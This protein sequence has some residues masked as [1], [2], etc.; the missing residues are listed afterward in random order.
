MPYLF[1]LI[2]LAVGLGLV[3]VGLNAMWKSNQVSDWPTATG[4]F[5]E[6]KLIEDSDSDSTTYRVVV[7]YVYSVAGVDFQSDR[8]AFGYMGSSGHEMHQSILD[9]LLRGESVRVRYNPA[10]PSEAVLAYGLNN[11]MLSLII[12]GAVWTIFTLGLFSLFYITGSADTRL[13]ERLMVQ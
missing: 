8:L 11:S 6:R 9:K 4:H 12:F 13:I 10:E 2:F 3:G 5:L 7:K 1:F